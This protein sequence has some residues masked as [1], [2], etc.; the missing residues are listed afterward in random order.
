MRYRFQVL[1]L[2][3]LALF[4]VC[5]A[6]SAEPAAPDQAFVRDHCISCHNEE[7]KKGR[8]DLT[9]LAFDTKDSNNLAVWVKVHDRVKAGEMPPKIRNRPD[10]ARLKDFVEGL[11][12]SI[13]AAERAALAG[14]GR[15]LLR[16]LNRQE[17]EN[18]VRDL[19]G[20]PWAP[21]ANRLPDDGEAYRFNKSGEALDVSHV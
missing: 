3:V 5:P 7:N 16:R 13:V 20:V 21:I 6:E 19:L 12:Q 10:A 4:A 11:G 14:D 17:Y 9:N 2:T 8:L 18:A 15:A 1:G